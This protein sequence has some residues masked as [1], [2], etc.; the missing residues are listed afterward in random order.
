MVSSIARLT[1]LL[2]SINN[3]LKSVTIFKLTQQLVNIF[4]RCYK[5]FSHP[6]LEVSNNWSTDTLNIFWIV[7]KNS[8]FFST[9][10]NIA[11]P[12]CNPFKTDLVH[13]SNFFVNIFLET[14]FDFFKKQSLKWNKEHFVSKN[15]KVSNYNGIGM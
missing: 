1:I 10:D 9:N 6:L 5:L 11:H 14:F 12:C 13:T 2:L 7:W 15:S 3:L 8:H 4:L